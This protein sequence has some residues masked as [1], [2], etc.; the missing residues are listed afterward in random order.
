MFV[1]GILTL[2]L[3]KGKAENFF[4]AGRSLPL[5]V[6]ILTLGSQS[7]DSNATLGNVDL[8]YRYQFWDGAVLPL[9]LG[10]SLIINGL[11]I[12]RHI[13]KANCLTLPDLYAKNFGPLVEVLVS[14]ITCISFLCLL[15]GNLVGLSVILSF[16][17][18]GALS[19]GGS[20]AI[21]A[22]V[23]FLYTCAGGLFSVAYTDVVQ[24]ALGFTGLCV[25]TWWMLANNDN[26]AP[27]PSVGF[28]GYIY[29]DDATCEL[30]QGVPCENSPDLCCYNEGL[31]GPG[32]DNGA[33]P[34]GDSKT[35]PNYMTDSDAFAPFPK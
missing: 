5:F 23:T 9:G 35:I 27:T 25:G 34:F 19:T 21:G 32:V 16:I 18:D 7:L 33:W 6:I 10:L 26:Y 17:T 1:V 29:P 12:A 8:A 2:F 28:P 11:F 30:Y 4:V 31:Y 22:A 15:A 14:L 20:V 3:V 24:A 13:N